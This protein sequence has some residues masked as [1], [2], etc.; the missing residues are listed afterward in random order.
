MGSFD[1][2]IIY[3]AIVFSFIE[4]IFNINNNGLF[5]NARNLFPC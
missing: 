3:F 5:D 2:Y 1:F 4:N